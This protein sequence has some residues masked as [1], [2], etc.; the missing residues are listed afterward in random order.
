MSFSSMIVT[1]SDFDRLIAAVA[2]GNQDA[3]TQLYHETSAGVYAYALSVL[4]N[5]QDAE[6][7]LQDCFLKIQSSAGAYR[8]KG[9]PMAWIFTITKNLCMDIMREKKKTAVL[10][11]DSGLSW[12]DPDDRLVVEACLQILTDEERQIVVLY[13]V[14]GIKHREVAEIMG[15]PL[16]TVL[17]K[18]RRALKKM[19]TYLGKE[20]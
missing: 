8:S 13:A 1:D 15:L 10:S 18:Y 9:K 7:V 4:K 5:S 11:Y 12:A 14:S 2:A 6:D 3:L 20:R 19:K 17:S 16:S